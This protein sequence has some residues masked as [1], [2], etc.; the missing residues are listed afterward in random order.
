MIS[1]SLPLVELINFPPDLIGNHYIHTI[2]QELFT[3]ALKPGGVYVLEDI[4]TSYIKAY[5][6]PQYIRTIDYLHSIIDT[7]NLPS[8]RRWPNV[9]LLP[10]AAEVGYV[11]CVSEACAF[12]KKP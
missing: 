11:L 9:T 5:V 6:E 8:S 2:I 3:D 10:E 1:P 7:L 4:H 12:K